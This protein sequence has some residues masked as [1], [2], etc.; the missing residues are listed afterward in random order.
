MMRAAFAVLG[1]ATALV[2]GIACSDNTTTGDGVEEPDGA[3]PTTGSSCPCT[4]GEFTISCGGAQCI[5]GKGYR[6]AD[7]GA[8]EDDSLCDAGGTSGTNG[9]MPTRSCT[10][11]P[12]QCGTVDDGC[13]SSLDCSTCPATQLCTQALVVDGGGADSWKCFAKPANVAVF[14]AAQGGTFTLAVDENLPNLAI[15]IASPA[16]VH[17]TITGAFAANVALVYVAGNTSST[18]SGAASFV[19]ASTLC[20]EPT[21]AGV[22]AGVCSPSTDVSTFFATKLGGTVVFNRCQADAF[23]GTLNVSDHGSC[24]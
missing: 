18:V 17:V 2:I 16:P 3:P 21:D 24:N 12:A 15:A 8:H 10:S 13:G 1:F 23:S 7:D 4:I 19:T 9:C 14:G 6:C 22:D 20:E 5:A 11:V